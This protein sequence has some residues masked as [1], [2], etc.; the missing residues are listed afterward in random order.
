MA[1]AHT[2]LGL[3]RFTAQCLSGNAG[4]ARLHAHL[5]YNITAFKGR[6]MKRI[7]FAL[8][9]VGMT[10]LAQAAEPTP[11][12]IEKLLVLSHA[13]KIL[14]AVKPQ[15][16]MALKNGMD[17]A[18]NGRKPSAKEQQVLDDFV[19]QSAHIMEEFLTMERLKPIYMQ[20]Y[21]QSFSQE[22]IDGLNAFYQSPAGNSMLT[23]MPQLMQGL[24]AAMPA[25]MAPMTQQLQQ[26]SKQMASKL[27]ALQKNASN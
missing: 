22:E 17:V 23:K 4:S 3:T 6:D 21:A 10:F 24:M 15:F 26:A 7:G 18:L 16:S 11:E 1:H 12:S 9:F 19:A 25:V 20:L 27:E 14:D 5:A 8:A 2:S 13:E